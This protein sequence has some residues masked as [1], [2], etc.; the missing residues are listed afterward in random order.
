[1]EVSITVNLKEGSFSISGNEEFVEKNKE[2]LKEYILLNCKK[3]DLSVVEDKTLSSEKTKDCNEDKYIKMGIYAVDKED[4]TVTIL[5]KIPG[6][7]NSEKTKN[8]AL[9]VLYAKGEGGKIQGSEI[10]GLC[11]K[12]KCYDSKNFAA[13]FKRDINNF[14]MKGKGQSWTLELSIPG[15]DNAI[16]LL[17]SMISND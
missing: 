12:Q 4:G 13:I 2:E 9:V 6:K 16:A 10:R 3:T 15:K 7:N 5:K 17:E 8:I 14:I 11:E 1:M